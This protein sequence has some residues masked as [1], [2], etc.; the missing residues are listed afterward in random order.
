MKLTYRFGTAGIAMIAALG[1]SSAANAAPQTAT[2]NA[3][4]EIVSALTITKAAD[5]DFGKIAINTSGTGGT[6]MVATSGAETCAATL[7]CYSTTSAAKFDITNGTVGKTLTVKLPA[8]ATLTTGGGA[9]NQ[10]LSLASFTTDATATATPGLYTVTLDSTGKAAF[11]VGG[12]LTLDGDEVQGA[13]SAPL[14]F[15]VDYQ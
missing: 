6:V 9:A 13:Y 7:T 11:A 2:A 1:L 10:Q 15:D 8:S 12:T 5:L 3:K 14:T 4:A